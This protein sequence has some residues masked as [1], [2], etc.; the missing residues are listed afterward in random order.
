[1]RV[2]VLLTTSFFILNRKI[3]TA[4][5]DNPLEAQSTLSLIWHCRMECFKSEHIAGPSEVRCSRGYLPPAFCLSSGKEGAE[6]KFLHQGIPC[7]IKRS[8]PPA[9]PWMCIYLKT[10][11][12][13]DKNKARFWGRVAYT[14]NASVLQRN[15]IRHANT[16]WRR[17]VKTEA[18]KGI[19][20]S[21]A[22]GL[23]RGKERFSL[24]PLRQEPGLAG[25]EEKK[26]APQKGSGESRKSFLYFLFYN[27][28]LQFT[29]FSGYCILLWILHETST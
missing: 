3:P 19:M 13:K 15:Q 28:W 4:F 20:K 2:A 26:M 11:I 29:Y 18:K 27:M 9:F 14:F 10:C 7:V 24:R 21:W 12:N 17:Q 22:I 23:K 25:S 1:M 5:R 6:N 16:R 8:I